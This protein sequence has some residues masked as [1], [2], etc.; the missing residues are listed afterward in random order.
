VYFE[1]T[2]TVSAYNVLNL[3]DFHREWIEEGLMEPENIR[4]NI[5][6]D[7]TYMRLQI[8]PPW[9]KDRVRKRYDD[10]ITYLN[11]FENTN[12]IIKDYESILKFM[13]TDRTDEIKMWFFKTNRVD[14]IRNEN[15]FDV[16]PEIKDIM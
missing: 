4:I 10:H 12:W 14:K 9:I 5:L 6:L 8:L 11:Q 15:V 3:P 16:F 7:P 1:L 13:E 2:P